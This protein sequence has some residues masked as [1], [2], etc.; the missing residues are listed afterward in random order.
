M[1]NIQLLQ[2]PYLISFSKN[3]VLWKFRIAPFTTAQVA[4]RLR[5]VLSVHVEDYFDSGLFR[6]VWRGEEY[7]NE[8]GLAYINIQ[9]ILDASL[10]YYVPDN[11]VV[12]IHRCKRQSKRYFIRYWYQD[13]NGSLSTETQS[14][15]LT[16]I[17]GGLSREEAHRSQFFETNVVSQR[18][19][20]HYWHAQERIRQ[21]E[22][23]WLY[24]CMGANNQANLKVVC[25]IYDASNAPLASY[26]AITQPMAALYGE[27][28]CLPISWAS[29][30][31]DA[32]ITP[33]D[34]VRRIEVN[35]VDD[36]GAEFTTLL[37][38]DIDY[39]PMYDVQYIYYRN[40]LGGL[41]TQ[42]LL[43]QKE[44]SIATQIQSSERI[45]RAELMALFHI[46]YEL[47]VHH[48]THQPGTTAHT[49]FIP[50]PQLQKLR[51][52][53]LQKQVYEPYGKRLRPL[54]L[55]SEKTSL[56]K[57]KDK[58]Y[59][60]AI[61]LSPAYKDENY[62]REFTVAQGSTCPAVEVLS[63]SQERGRY[64]HI[65]WELPPGYDKIEI[66]YE[67][68]GSASVIVTY[69]GQI[70]DADIQ[71]FNSIFPPTANKI[72]SVKARVVCND[73]IAPFSYGPHSADSL[74]VAQKLA[75][76]AIP[77]VVDELPR[78]PGTYILQQ[79]GV[80]LD[81]TA[82]DLPM[83]GGII[84]AIQGLYDALGAAAT[85]SANGAS[86]GINGLTGVK[87]TPN[88]ASLAITTEDYF[89]Y[90]ANEAVPPSFT[91][92][93]NLAKI[94]VP[95][96]A[97]QAKIWVKWVYLNS[98]AGLVFFGLFNNYSTGES[99][100]TVAIQFYADAAC[101][102]PIDVTGLGYTI[103]WV[104]SVIT[105]NYN[106]IGNV[107]SVSGPVDANHTQLLTGSSMILFAPLVQE[108]V[109]NVSAS[110]CDNDETTII[111][112]LPNTIGNIEYVDWPA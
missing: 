46:Q 32:N 18:H 85:T 17:K 21:N 14:D 54:R 112:D 101:T 7:P 109:Y 92:F 64:L 48:S 56:Y 11:N 19:T 24:F 66:E 87:Y 82:N 60:L 108:L 6:E 52:L 97:Q 41:D 98:Q 43:G 51:D 31:I 61:D 68:A 59:N 12:K 40:S 4:S 58:L 38:F 63:L 42:P 1:F 79:G 83:N 25:S 80:D 44:H 81:F 70:G 9:T 30:Q 71:V 26:D 35:V 107:S 105:K 88:P 76:I 57:S 39:R 67:I 34:V 65:H 69:L 93:S 10:E 23:K 110:G 102:T 36:L 53:L 103:A 33:G 62:S 22:V 28:L 75:P 49:G 73:E 77:D 55:N 89:Y 15:T 8:R 78:L 2:A 94:V 96:K 95:I 111:K 86:I 29:L 5:L 37:K 84:D 91:M 90:R 3:P 50:L 16:V 72:V 47:P 74:S 45:Q 27:V 99:S 13:E 106:A 20:L 104:K 100:S